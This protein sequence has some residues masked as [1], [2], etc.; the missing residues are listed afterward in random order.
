M[1]DW[2]RFKDHDLIG[3]FEASVN[4][5]LKKNKGWPLVNKKKQ[6][7][8]KHYEH[9]GLFNFDSFT[10][11]NK[12]T[13]TD[14]PEYQKVVAAVKDAESKLQQLQKAE[15]DKH[16]LHY[17]SFRNPMTF[18]DYLSSGLE[19]SLMV[20]V[21]YTASNGDPD[22]TYSLHYQATGKP[23]QYEQAIVSVG[24]ILADYDHDGN[25]PLFGFGATKKY[26][27]S[28]THHCFPIADTEEVKGV[29]GLITAYKQSFSKFDLS[30]PTNFSPCIE[31][32]IQYAKEM[33]QA[34]IKSQSLKYM[35]LLMI[36]DGDISDMEQCVKSIVKASD[37]P[38]SIVIVGVGS[39]SFTSMN[40]L[41]ADEVPLN[42]GDAY[43]VRDTVQFVP[44]RDFVK[45]P[46]ALAEATLREIPHQVTS[47][48][49]MK[50]IY[51]FKKQQQQY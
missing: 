15:N 47:Y 22:K 38:L 9:S 39:N 35:V 26:G 33:E 24:T 14:N 45:D 34:Y 31:Q 20:C 7:T 36:T 1:W 21:D 44:F 3:S 10:V 4:E 25:F 16:K 29:E 48:Y 8:K 41:D 27:S 32:A 30:G 46:Q 51:P 37:K 40:E 43:A 50:S 19:I 13:K 6:Q 12:E 5:I 28:Q 42:S 23:S 2:D 49:A 18:I 17:R 11:N